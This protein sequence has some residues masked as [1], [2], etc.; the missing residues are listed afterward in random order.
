MFILCPLVYGSVR[1]CWQNI[2]HLYFFT[3]IPLRKILTG[4]CGTGFRNHTLAYGVRGP[5]PCQRKLGQN[6][7]FTI[8]NA[9]KLTTFEAILHEIGQILPKCCYL[10]RKKPVGIRSKWP[11]FAENISLWLRS[12]S[13][14]NPWLRKLGSKR[15]LCWRQPPRRWFETPLRSPWCHCNDLFR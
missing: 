8:G 7:N 13:K 9:T 2:Q 6:Q 1:P 14:K 10:L 15:D 5:K 12:L 4:V 3:S 11:K